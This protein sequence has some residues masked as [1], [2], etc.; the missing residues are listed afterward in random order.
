MR[1]STTA[2]ADA[3]VSVGHPGQRVRALPKPVSHPHHGSPASRQPR[4]TAAPHQG[5]RRTVEKLTGLAAC[6]V[7]PNPVEH[8]SKLLRRPRRGMS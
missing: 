6:G 8:R 5:R 2:Q 3:V 1:N 7:V 4:I